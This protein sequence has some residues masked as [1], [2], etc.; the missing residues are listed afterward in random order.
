ML[1]LP[2]QQEKRRVRKGLKHVDILQHPRMPHR[3]GN[4]R[5]CARMTFCAARSCK[6]DFSGASFPA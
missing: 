3:G 1:R 5:C 6:P 2:A 4:A